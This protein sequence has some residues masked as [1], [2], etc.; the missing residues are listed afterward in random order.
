MCGREHIGPSDRVSCCH[1]K[2]P[3]GYQWPKR[4]G[5]H[6]CQAGGSY[7]TSH[8]SSAI[9]VYQS[10]YIETLNNKGTVIHSDTVMTVCTSPGCGSG[11]TGNTAGGTTGNTS[12]GTTSGGNSNSTPV[13]DPIPVVTIPTGGSI[14]AA[15]INDSGNS[16]TV[17]LGAFNANN[18]SIVEYQVVWST[19]NSNPGSG[20]ITRS[21]TGSWTQPVGGN[22]N[23]TWY[24]W[25]RARNSAGWSG[26][27]GSTSATTGT[28]PGKPNAPTLNNRA[29]DELEF[30]IQNPSM[31]TGT[32]VRHEV[33][34]DMMYA[35][36]G[37]VYATGNWHVGTTSSPRQ[38]VWA[39]TTNMSDIGK[40]VRVRTR[41]VT[42]VGTGDWSDYFY[43][44][45]P[46]GCKVQVSGAPNTTFTGTGS[47][48][49]HAWVVG[50]NGS[51]TAPAV[52][53]L[54][55]TTSQTRQSNLLSI[56]SI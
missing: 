24:F 4:V 9:G 31:G 17:T 39:G 44:H 42:G 26:W 33:Q 41:A 34:A 22:P 36:D 38:W 2:A 21:S 53:N 35:T 10:W 6:Q 13:V 37:S 20:G 40:Y 56:R 47:G 55:N 45:I 50:A 48:T 16:L 54:S 8:T 30:N 3:T 23:T 11:S 14:S 49:D 32:F 27:V 12:G 46:S 1:S 18:G 19:A 28:L 15:R 43:S 52:V 25:A 51:A 7:V 5:A 29:N